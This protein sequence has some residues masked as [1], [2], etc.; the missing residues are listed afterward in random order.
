MKI[1][2]T[3]NKITKT[4]KLKSRCQKQ[5]FLFSF[6]LNWFTK[7]TKMYKTHIDILKKLQKQ[8]N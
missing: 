2:K 1:T 7:I 6:S 8:Q 3:H 4:L 5:H